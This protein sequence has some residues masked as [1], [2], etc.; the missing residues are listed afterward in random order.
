MRITKTKVL[1]CVTLFVVVCLV[2]V[3]VQ[4]A[5]AQFVIASWSYPDE[6]GQGIESF[7]IFE[8]STG[9]WVQVGGGYGYEDENIFDWEAGK[10]IRLY[11]YVFMNSTL[12]G[13][14]DLTDGLDYIR[15]NVTVTDSFSSTVYE[16]DDLTNFYKTSSIDPILWFYGYS[17]VLDF[18]PIGGLAYT[19]TITYEVYW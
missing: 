3:Q 16:E 11:I 6:Y 18:E 12:T 14:S 13:A 10:F 19:V 2:F 5:R 8:N 1:A 7:V 15:L 4:P 17:T 9:S